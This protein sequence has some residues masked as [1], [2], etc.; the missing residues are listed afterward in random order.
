MAIIYDL[1]LS[2]VRMVIKNEIL[3]ELFKGYMKPEDLLGEGGLLIEQKKTLI[4]KAL[5]GKLTHHLGYPKHAFSGLGTG[6]SR[7]G[8]FEPQLI[9]KLALNQFAIMFGD[10]LPMQG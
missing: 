2:L 7:N 5:A 4:E 10:R 1:V 9:W 6:N 8:S 3:D